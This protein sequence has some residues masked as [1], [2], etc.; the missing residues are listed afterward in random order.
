MAWELTYGPIPAGAFICHH[1]DVP[2][3]VRP[4]HLFLGTARDNTADMDAKGRRRVGTP[5]VYSGGDHWTHKKPERLK[6][7][8]EHGRA[9]I[10][11]AHVR[12]I[13][14]RHAAG[15]NYRALAR[16]FGISN[17]MIG[18]IVRRKSWRHVP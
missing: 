18:L 5:R 12:T 2:A 3:C 7:G 10:T 17:V 13:R 16:L 9:K 14:E 8:E 6:R 11:E 1:C 15:E 4:G